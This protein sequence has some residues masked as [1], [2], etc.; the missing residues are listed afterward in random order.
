M[1][2][3]SITFEGFNYTRRG[4]FEAHKLVLATMLTFRINIRKELI[5]PD[6]VA[7]LIKKE[8]ALDPP[9]CPD[10]LAKYLN[11]TVWPAVIGLQSVKIFE[12]L[13]SA[14]ESEA[15]QWK[16]WYGDE[17]A[18]LAELPKS[19]KDISQFHRILLLRALRPDR[20]QGALTQYVTDSLGV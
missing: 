12:N 17:K 11:E 8:V 7:S 2:L 10:N 20:L 5:K 9:P 14:M 6:E 15:L 4:T 13:V 1:I 19:F 18:E 3:E 16:K